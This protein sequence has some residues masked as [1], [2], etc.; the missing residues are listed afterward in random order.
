LKSVLIYLLIPFCLTAQKSRDNDAYFNFLEQMYLENTGSR[1]NSF[2]LKEL[3]LH[4][5]IYPDSPNQPQILHMLADI[6]YQSSRIPDAVVIYLRLLFQF[7]QSESSVQVKKD[8]PEILNKCTSLEDEA[9]KDSII[10]AVSRTIPSSKESGWFEMISFLYSTQIDTL[11]SL[12]LE[13]INEF[14]QLYGR[15]STYND[16]LLFWSAQLMEKLDQN[17]SAY[18]AYRQLIA[19]YPE[20]E[21]Y[22]NALLQAAMAVFRCPVNLQAARN[23]FLEVINNFAESKEAAEAQFYLAKLYNDSLRQAEEALNSYQ[24]FVENHPE[25]ELVLQALQCWGKLAAKLEKWPEAAEAWQ[26]YYELSP[27]DSTSI[28]VLKTL[29]NIHLEKQKN[30]ENGARILLIYAEQFKDPQKMYLAAQI[31]A[32]TL[33]NK[34]NAKE[35]CRKLIELFPESVYAAQA[36]KLL[37]ELN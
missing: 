29:I 19:M 34:D 4:L 6:N 31:Y 33:K 2:L 8:F 32:N 21:L 37:E 28:D 15:E 16:L 36:E 3:R 11:S 17:S 26:Q 25:N 9:A 10:S 5:K 14:R 23:Y 7:P 27:K 12:L 30:Y 35:T 13:E 24:L 1:N 18:A 22:K 20:S